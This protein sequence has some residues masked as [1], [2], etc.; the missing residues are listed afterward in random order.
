MRFAYAV[1]VLERAIGV[2]S[3]A[4]A[5]VVS[6]IVPYAACIGKQAQTD[7]TRVF[8]ARHREEQLCGN[9]GFFVTAVADFLAVFVIDFRAQRTAFKAA[10]RA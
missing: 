3:I 7:G 6:F 10:N 1:H 9:V 5:V 4:A 8:N 2:I